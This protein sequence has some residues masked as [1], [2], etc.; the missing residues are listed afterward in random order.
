MEIIN[1]DKA[2]AAIGP[3]SQAVRVRDFVFCSGQIGI[4]PTTKGLAGDDVTTQTRQVFKNIRAVMK[5][6]GLG[7]KNIIKTTVFLTNMNDFPVVN[8]IYGS[9]FKDHKPARSTVQV[10]RLPMDA[11]IEIECIAVTKK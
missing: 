1:S 4:D 5:A 6:S 2:S 3:Y 10:A 7:L 11:L 9:E 8:D